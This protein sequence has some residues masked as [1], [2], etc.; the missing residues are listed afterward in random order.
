MTTFTR[1]HDSGRKLD[2]HFCK[3][4]ETTVV[5]EAEAVPGLRGLAG[6][7][8]DDASWIK[9]PRNIWCVSKQDW[10]N[11]PNGSEQKKQGSSSEDY[12]P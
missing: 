2:F 1:I 3:V 6:G 7:T 11:L 10:Y 5:W 12:A 4:C 9:N 8:F